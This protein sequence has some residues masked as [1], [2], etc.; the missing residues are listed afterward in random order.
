MK[1]EQKGKYYIQSGPYRISKAFVGGKT[2][3]SAWVPSQNKE[4]K[5][6]VEFLDTFDKV[7][8]AKGACDDH[9]AKYQE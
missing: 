9:R 1:W 5:Y 6:K 8:A 2:V 3:Y 7:D 4:D